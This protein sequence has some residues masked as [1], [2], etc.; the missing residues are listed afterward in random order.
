MTLQTGV[1]LGAYEIIAPLG[2]D[3]VI[4]AVCPCSKDDRV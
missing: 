2:A 3:M 1:R 4:P